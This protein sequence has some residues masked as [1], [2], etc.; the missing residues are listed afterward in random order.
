MAKKKADVESA[1]SVWIQ[2]TH[3]ADIR[4]QYGVTEE[5]GTVTVI[6][7]LF[8]REKYSRDTGI[9]TDTGYT[10]IS[11]ELHE[12]LLKNSKVYREDIEN[13]RLVMFEEAPAAALT[14]SQQVADLTQKLGLANAKIAELEETVLKLTPPKPKKEE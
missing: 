12:D 10:E 2:N 8:V 1:G 3:S 5:D 14:T 4:P 9:V 6:G 13:G 11:K 7:Q